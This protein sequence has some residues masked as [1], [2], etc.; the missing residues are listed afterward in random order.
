[1]TWS[2]FKIWNPLY[3]GA[4]L[5]FF[6]GAIAA[7]VFLGG[8]K[9]FPGKEAFAAPKRE[10]G[11]IGEP[12]LLQAEA[13]W[14][15]PFGVGQI[16]L[17]LPLQSVPLGSENLVVCS[18]QNKVFYPAV[19][20]GPL[21]SWFREKTGL[22][23]GRYTVYFLFMGKDPLEVYIR[24]PANSWRVRVV[25]GEHPGRFRRLLDKWQEAFG[26]H[27]AGPQT[28]DPLFI[29][30]YLQTML[31]RRL[32]QAKTDASEGRRLRRGSALDSH[33]ERNQTPENSGAWTLLGAGWGWLFGEESLR[34]EM[35]R[36]RIKGPSQHWQQ[37]AE[38]L[39][40]HW[41]PL[42]EGEFLAPKTPPEIEP[43]ATR[44]PEECFYI[45]FGS[46]A[47]FAWF[48][49]LLDWAS[50][51]WTM[52]AEG[53][54]LDYQVVQRSEERLCLRPTGWS[55][56]LGPQMGAQVETL[57]VADVAI[58]GLDLFPRDGSGLGVLFEAR[59]EALLR[60]ELQR[61]RSEALRSGQGNVQEEKLQ[62]EGQEVSLLT[63]KDGRIRSFY[64]ADGPWHLVST[65]RRLVERFLQ[66]RS[67][68]GAL[69]NAPDFRAIR[70]KYPPG[71]NQTAFWY[72][73]EAFWRTV[74]SPG[75]QVER[76]RRAQ[77][78]A[79]VLLVEMARQAA[80]AEGRP[81]DTIDAL[82]VQGFLPAE[83]G[84]RS[85]GSRAVLKAGQVGDSLR[86][87]R[88]Y[89]TPIADMEVSRLSAAE[90]E[91]MEGYVRLVSAAQSR[92]RPMGLVFRRTEAEKGRE[93]I[94]L[95]IYTYP[96]QRPILGTL[97]R[98]FGPAASERIRP[99]PGDVA[100]A[101][102]W[103]PQGRLFLGLRAEQPAEVRFG[104]GKLLLELLP[105]GPQLLLQALRVGY[106]G[107]QG[108]TPFLEMV[109]KLLAGRPDQEGYTGRP[110]GLWR[111]QI[112]PFVLYSFD[113]QILAEVGP[114]VQ[115]EQTDQPAQ[116]RIQIKDPADSP[117]GQ[118]VGQLAYQQAR[119]ATLANLRL[120]T[121]LENQFH[122]SGQAA[123][124][125]AQRWHQARLVCP[126]GGGYEYRQVGQGGWH[127]VAT[128]LA[129]QPAS[130]A[131]KPPQQGL[132]S[133]RPA[134]QKGFVSP[135]SRAGPGGEGSASAKTS[136]PPPMDWFR[137]LEGWARWENKE[138]QIFI[139]LL[140]QKKPLSATQ[141]NSSR[142]AH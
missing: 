113:R 89:F 138:V 67:G 54:G 21:R 65:S 14:G 41:P 70:A 60:A 18:P 80:L 97:S 32:G 38:H 120:L 137:G 112:G 109:E 127:W 27:P 88:G 10:N 115:L 11:A 71:P 19:E 93:R 31:V 52:A 130:S 129:D 94:D 126:L 91:Q 104:R 77:A 24:T 73:S 15:E 131:P 111:R 96:L 98:F 117:L 114:L 68:Q 76:R 50:R 62:I 124:E 58:I 17:A 16:S 102:C 46:M 13:F 8:R 90:R 22:S 125:T 35:L 99:P 49:E 78:E 40:P 132:L 34:A 39:L 36:E 47:N 61:Q 100:F 136:L 69:A 26:H 45:R 51:Q 101:E 81:A 122:L 43:L 107:R 79:D 82:I 123:L 63:S 106:V 2:V 3:Q 30:E 37:P 74:F 33:P 83:F 44:T 4:Y 121:M 57:A 53:K 133:G 84:P 135:S 9:D 6:G 105:P 140:R 5:V 134:I 116:V 85:D 55:R 72:F 20:E 86:G 75:Y 119:Q 108:E 29:K 87:R 1:M 12:T 142:P 42:S 141:A 48:R 64:V 92:L 95:E 128:A 103:V 7:T 66:T 139:S 110:G 28:E 23:G 56:L 25:P 118:W 59:A